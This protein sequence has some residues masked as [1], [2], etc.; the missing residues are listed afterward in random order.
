M[1]KSIKHEIYSKFIGNKIKNIFSKN[2]CR[3]LF[4]YSSTTYGKTVSNSSL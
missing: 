4:I 1:L 2:N 3:Y